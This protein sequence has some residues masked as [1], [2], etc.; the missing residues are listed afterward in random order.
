MTVTVNDLT[1]EA[2]DSPPVLRYLARPSAAGGTSP[3]VR[4]VVVLRDEEPTPSLRGALVVAS[5][6]GIGEAERFMSGLAR[7]EAAGLVVVPEGGACAQTELLATRVRVPVLEPIRARSRDAVA[8]MVLTRQLEL[9]E[10]RTERLCRVFDL[11]AALCRRGEGPGELLELLRKLIGGQV[12]LIESRGGEASVGVPLNWDVLARVRSGEMQSASYVERDRHVLLHPLTSA[13]LY[14]GELLVL[15]AASRSPW[16]GGQQELLL[17]AAAQVDLVHQSRQRRVRQRGIDEAHSVIRE[18]ALI[19][20][21]QGEVVPASMVLRRLLPEVLTTE[22][23][24]VGVLQ[25]APGEDRGLVRDEIE[26]VLEGSALVVECPVEP[27][28]VVVL[29]GVEGPDHDLGD[30]PELARRLRPVVAS[31]GERRLGIAQ[32]SKWIETSA[33]YFDARQAL[34]GAVSSPD[35]I[36]THDGGAPLAMRLPPSARAWAAA[37]LPS[38]HDLPRA[39]RAQLLTSVGY[40]LALGQRQAARL[41]PLGRG[42]HRSTLSDRVTQLLKM[43]GLQSRQADKAVLHLALQLGGDEPDVVA[44]PPPVLREVLSCEEAQRWAKELLHPLQELPKGTRK[45][46]ETWVRHDGVQESAA[47]ALGISRRTFRRRLDHIS[48]ALSLPL[49]GPPWTGL[50]AVLFA[51]VIE[52]MSSP[53]SPRAGTMPP[54]VLPDPVAQSVRR[55]GNRP[56]LDA[57]LPVESASSGRPRDRGSLRGGQRD[58][59]A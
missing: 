52:S 3:V 50:Y 43:T 17:K 59:A 37:L 48:A 56:A 51:L 8:S 22:W 5:G 44:E 6:T 23:V 4:R 1:R 25:C 33:A 32:L 29:H 12:S 39:E 53:R 7:A 38:T 21:I 31:H 13:N 36:C 20:L 41:V 42:A 2:S 35:R 15:A 28:D 55:S 54:D 14:T 24:Q 18:S 57:A 47:D 58:V 46:L 11:S 26:R 34:A 19:H 27:L 40:V 49:A 10:A 30:E 45:L 16:T 9:L